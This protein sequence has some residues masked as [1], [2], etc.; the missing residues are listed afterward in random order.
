MNKNLPTLV[1]ALY[2]RKGPS[3]RCL[4]S[5]SAAE[6]PGKE[7]R[8]VISI[9]N[10]DNKNRDIL[11][12]AE[13][14]RWEHGE[15]EVIYHESNLG[16][17]NHFN[18]CGDLTEEYGS[19][20]FLED[21]LFVSGYYYDYAVQALDFF[22]E[23]EHV[24]GISLYSYHRLDKGSN[25]LPFTPVDDGS[26]N[27]FLQ[28]ASW[29]QIWTCDIWREYKKWFKVNG[30][31]EYVNGLPDVPPE[32]KGWPASSF[33]KLFITYMILNHKYY[34]FPRVSLITNFDDIGTHRKGQTSN[35]QSPLLIREKKFRFSSFHDSLSIYDSY[36]EILP[37]II[38]TLNPALSG[39]DFEVNLYGNKKLEDI[40]KDIVLSRLK[41]SENIKKFNRIMKP[42]DL[43][44]IFD[45]EGDAIFLSY[46][47]D[48]KE[49]NPLDTFIDDFRYFY[50]AVPYMKEI[51]KMIVYKI[52][53]KF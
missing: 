20:I 50:R 36:F 37:G 15:K 34:V 14:Y 47:E 29:G 16:L 7:V 17:R 38:K 26:D 53:R 27:Y 8:L 43:N 35:V 13:N 2:N 48:L 32:V 24:A 11:E 52:K 33:K 18:F 19:V 12:L 4:D 51:I 30:N 28:Q 25:P 22:R 46:K 3:L 39:Y 6:Y 5:L 44:V 40:T 42:H 1:L 21:D 45:R 10:D 31:D 49:G 41:G 9:D 23:D